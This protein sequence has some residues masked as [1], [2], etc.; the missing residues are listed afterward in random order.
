MNHYSVILVYQSWLIKTPHILRYASKP[1]V[2]ICHEPLL[3]YY[4]PR[5][6]EIQTLKEQ[7]INIIRLPIKWMDRKNIGGR[8][9][10]VIANSLYSKK[11]IDKTYGVSSVIVHPGIDTK[12]FAK[13]K[14]NYKAHQVISVGALNKFKR[15][16]FYVDVVSKVP[17]KIRP[18]LV[19]IGNGADVKYLRELKNRAKQLHVKLKI[20]L[21][22]SEEIKLAEYRKSKAFLF[23][24]TSEPFGLVVIEAIACG[25]PVLLY[26]F[27]GGYIEVV[28]ETNGILFKNLNPSSWAEELEHILHN[29]DVQIRYHKVNTL[30]AVANYDSNNMNKSILDLLRKRL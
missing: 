15:Q 24:P 8:D 13:R 21:N 23:A 4:D 12:K 1:K 9:I 20:Y 28:N 25:I 30:F 6:I 11:L 17:L 3:E 10:T 5:H 2:Y 16:L 29:S 7:L 22:A 14:M 19:L 27:G 18:K 26:K